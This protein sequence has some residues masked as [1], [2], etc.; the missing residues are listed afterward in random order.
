[1]TVP[2][3]D[4]VVVC[5]QWGFVGWC[6]VSFALTWSRGLWLGASWY[7]C[8]AGQLYWLFLVLTGIAS[9]ALQYTVA[10][11]LL[12]GAPPYPACNNNVRASPD[13][14]VW[15]LYHYWTLAV[16]HD[17]YNGRMLASWLR[18]GRRILEGVA[19]PVILV[20]TGNTTWT[21]AA[22]G[23]AFGVAMGLLSALLLLLVWLPRMHTIA[24]YVDWLGFGHH[25]LRD[26]GSFIFF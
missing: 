10:T 12:H 2:D 8:R 7:A 17:A 23:A 1:M 6:L 4:V 9:W 16:I 14:A 20:L 24:L 5:Y 13:L 11:L 15:L 22:E 3:S 19:V 26:D 25:N 18:T 21:Y